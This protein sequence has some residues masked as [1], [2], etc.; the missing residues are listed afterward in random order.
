MGTIAELIDKIAE[1]PPDWHGAGTVGRAVLRAIVEHAASVGTI[2]HSVETGSGLTTLLFSHLSENHHVFALD[3][4]D[5]VSRVRSSPLFKS[6]NVTYVEG[7]TQVTLPRYILPPGIQIALIDGPH[8]YPF[9]DME[10]F[11]FYPLIETGALL[12]VDDIQ[13]PSVGRMFEI[14]KADDM[15]ELVDIVNDNM[16]FFRRTKAPLVDPYGD[17]WWLQGYNRAHYN[18]WVKKSG[19]SILK[20]FLRGAAGVA[21]KGLKDLLPEG[22]KRKLWSQM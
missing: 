7:P 3:M 11:Y 12:L 18:E 21:P 14:L 19:P 10:Y 13:I 8:G 2:H 5:S 1:L 6:E 9:P 20:R 4:H 22:I 17:G 15:F 16:A